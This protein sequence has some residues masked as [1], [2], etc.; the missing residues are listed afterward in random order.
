MTLHMRPKKE[1]NQLA[2]K[3]KLC[4][5]ED[6]MHLPVLVPTLEGDGDWAGARAALGALHT[7]H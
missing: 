6:R 4:G 1:T 7:R 2:P 5:F 3:Q